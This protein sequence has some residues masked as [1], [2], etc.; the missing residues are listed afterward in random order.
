MFC[1]YTLKTLNLNERSEGTGQPLLTQGIL[2]KIQSVIPSDNTISKYE[3]ISKT[4]F[5]QLSTH[6]KELEALE[7]L[8]ATILSKMTKG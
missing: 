5:E 7:N 3:L 4:L 6:S 2:N 8:R 1:F